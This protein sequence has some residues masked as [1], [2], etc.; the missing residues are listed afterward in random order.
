[1]NG[2]DGL[3]N[4][5]RIQ[6]TPAHRRVVQVRMDPILSAEWRICL[7]QFAALLVGSRAAGAG[8][9]GRGI[10]A[11]VRKLYHRRHPHTVTL[12]P[13]IRSLA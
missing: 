2:P 3:V 10:T 4:L 5:S 11:S 7:C 12:N 9:I 1:M 8:S 6:V 13:G